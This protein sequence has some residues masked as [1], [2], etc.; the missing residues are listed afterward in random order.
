MPTTRGS[1]G[2]PGRA[3][4]RWPAR[5]RRLPGHAYDDRPMSSMAF[6]KMQGTGND[7]VVTESE[8]DRSDW[9]ALAEQICDRHFGVGADGLIVALPSAVAE[10][11]MRIFNPDGSEAEMCGNGVRCFVKYLL[12]RALVDALDGVVRVETMSGVLEARATR[13][14][15]GR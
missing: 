1:S 3:S 9:P 7:F 4:K 12:D 2:C 15:I 6:W 10:R 8:A 5:L 11:R 14:E 13:D